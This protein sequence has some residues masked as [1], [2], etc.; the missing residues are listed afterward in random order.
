MSKIWTVYMYCFPNNKRYIGA[1]CQL[2]SAR[3]GARFQK[4]KNN[5]LLWS[6][7]Q[8]FGTESIEQTV[9]CKAYSEEEASEKEKAYISQYRTC[10]PDYGYNICNGG[11]GFKKK[12]LSEKQKEE[13]CIQLKKASEERLKYP[14]SLETRRKQS[15]AKL[16]KKRMPM[17]EE[18]K[19]KISKANS[20]ENM[21]EETRKR[22]KLSKIKKVCATEKSSGI[23][24]VFDSVED[25][26]RYFSVQS[27]AVSRWISGERKPRNDYTFKFI[28]PPTTTERESTDNSD[29]TV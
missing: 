17:S 4:Y 29:A 10:D 20:R 3:Q 9:L 28:I 14:V 21:S 5:T 24:L 23:E 1:T 19:A 6:A 25:T 11:E 16:G 7:I 22:R 8:E 18:T 15:L 26:A 2:L 27:S 12:P 13:L